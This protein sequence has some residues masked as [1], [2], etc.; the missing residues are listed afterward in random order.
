MYFY[1][2]TIENLHEK[3]NVVEMTFDKIK[4]TFI[5]LKNSKQTGIWEELS[6]IAEVKLQNHTGS[7]MKW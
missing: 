2:N 3:F 7:M 1:F 5:F 4:H 6:K